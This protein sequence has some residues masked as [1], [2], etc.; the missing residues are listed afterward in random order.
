V[1]DQNGVGDFAA[2]IT[3]R[4]AERCVVQAKLGETLAGFEV[5]VM[6]N[7]V[8]FGRRGPCG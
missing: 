2:G 6:G 8:A 7:V 1:E 4:L 3:L 5:E